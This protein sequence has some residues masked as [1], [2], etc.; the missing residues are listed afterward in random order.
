M[1]TAGVKSPLLSSFGATDVE[2]VTGISRITLH[3]WDRSG[4]FRPSVAP[5][6]KGTGNR[7]KYSFADVIALR[8]IKRLRDEGISLRSLRRVAAKVRE[9][10]K[11]ENPFAERFLAVSG[12]DVLLMRG[13]EAV[14]VLAAPGQYSLFLRLDLGA[15]VERVKLALGARAA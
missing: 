3:A 4:F 10:E 6:G 9:L 12:R 14:S 5:G 15:E 13:D 1:G 2:R 8:V 11:V 7:R